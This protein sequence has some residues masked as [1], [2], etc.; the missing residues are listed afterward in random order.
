MLLQFY[1]TLSP[2][3]ILIVQHWPKGI[4]LRYSNPKCDQ[5]FWLGYQELSPLDHF[6]SVVTLSSYYYHFPTIHLENGHHFMSPLYTCT[7]CINVVH[8]RERPSSPLLI[9]PA[10][11]SVHLLQPL[12]TPPFTTK[13][14]KPYIRKRS[15][16]DLSGARGVPGHSSDSGT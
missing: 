12:M 13:S 5:V 7:M 8:L 3:N 4:Q 9:T 15:V 11:G 14:H 1:P 2:I 10:S 16:V 6:K